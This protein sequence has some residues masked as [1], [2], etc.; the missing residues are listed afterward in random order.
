MSVSDIEKIMP[1]CYNKICSSVLRF[2]KRTLQEESYEK[3]GIDFY[4]ASVPDRLYRIAKSKQ[5]KP[6]NCQFFPSK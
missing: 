2:A 5:W 4:D 1:W 6:A 3:V